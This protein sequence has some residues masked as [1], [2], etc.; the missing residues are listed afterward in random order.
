L[1]ELALSDPPPRIVLVPAALFL[2][3]AVSDPPPRI[4]LVPLEL[5]RTELATKPPPLTELVP[6]AP[7]AASFCPTETIEPP[8]RA[9][10]SA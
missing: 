5:L 8:P 1:L 7:G 3:V 9:V 6:V 4:A 10:E 2:A